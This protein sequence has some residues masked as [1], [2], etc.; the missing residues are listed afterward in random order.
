ML[1]VPMNISSSIPP[2]IDPVILPIEDRNRMA[3]LFEEVQTRL[4]EMAMITARTLRMN[5]D[6]CSQI[7][8]RPYASGTD[9][10]REAVELI[11]TPHHRGG[12][13]R[14]PALVNNLLTVNGVFPMPVGET[15]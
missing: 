2:A 4:E 1:I 9:S 7:T 12:Y 5:V 13:E 15:S 11:R 10:E 14:R 8:F 3:R 6:R